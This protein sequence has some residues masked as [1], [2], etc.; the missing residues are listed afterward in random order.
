MTTS[1]GVQPEKI[2]HDNLRLV[3]APAKDRFE[4]HQDHPDTGETTFIGFIGYRIADDESNV[5]VLQHTI[6]AEEFGRQG[7][8]RALTTLVLEQLKQQEQ[9]FINQCSYI[10]GYLRRYPEYLELVANPSANP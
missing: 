6:V 3:D 2:V 5:Y 8:A 9:K 7:Y 1:P 10:E 4:L